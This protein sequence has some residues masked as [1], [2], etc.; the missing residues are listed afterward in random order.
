MLKNEREVH[1]ED[2]T[3]RLH[4]QAKCTI[5]GDSVLKNEHE[6]H[7]Q[8]KEIARSRMSAKCTTVMKR[9]ARKNASEVHNN[10]K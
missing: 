9:S 10:T 6:M 3:W 4:L 5:R 1:D 2:G 8:K 7:N